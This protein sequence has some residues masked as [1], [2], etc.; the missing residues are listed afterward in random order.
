MAQ[1]RSGAV[2]QWRNGYTFVFTTS[3]RVKPCRSVFTQFTDLSERNIDD[4]LCTKNLLLLI[5]ECRCFPNSLQIH[6]LKLFGTS[7]I[8]YVV[9]YWVK[10]TLPVVILI[11]YTI[12]LLISCRSSDGL[13]EAVV[14]VL[15]HCL[16][17]RAGNICHHQ[18]PARLETAEEKR[19]L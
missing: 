5:T 8:S 10:Y 19:Q 18:P 6:W 4:Y 12:S 13:R 1:W 15:S 2:A 3:S 14:G 7:I 9:D 17:R 16:V 11:R